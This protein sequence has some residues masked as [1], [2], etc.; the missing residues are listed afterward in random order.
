[1][2]VIAKEEIVAKI[3]EIAERVA[4]SE[5]IEIVDVQLLGAGRGR[6]LRIFIDRPAVRSAET[7]PGDTS[8]AHL[9]GVSHADCEFISH[10]VGT[11]LDIEDVIPGDSYT[12][13][14]SSPGLERKLSKA[15][16]FE[17]FVGQKAKVVLREPVENQRSWEGRLAGISEGVIALEPAAGRIIH[18]QL[19]QVQKANL[20]FD[21]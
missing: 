12:L 1:M 14:V 7:G 18:F 19:D 10:Q 15:K 6:L 4:D 16:D 20:K 13:E 11:I 5:G 2:S 8:P 3:A 9:Q 21:W 17:R